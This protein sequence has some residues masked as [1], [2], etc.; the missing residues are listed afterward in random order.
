MLILFDYGIDNLLET[1][2]NI[3]QIDNIQNIY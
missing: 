1:Q 3:Y 2:D